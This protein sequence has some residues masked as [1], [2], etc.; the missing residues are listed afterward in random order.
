MSEVRGSSS[1]RDELAS[2]VSDSGIRYAAAD[3]IEVSTASFDAGFA[4]REELEQ[5]E[6]FKDQIKGFAIAWGE[7]LVDLARGCKDIVEQNVLTEDS[8]IVQ[9]LRNPCAKAS[10][11]LRYLNEFCRRIAIRLTLGR[12]YSWSINVNT[13]HD[14]L[15][16]SVK[17]VQIHP[18]SASHVLLPDGRRLAY[19]EQGV[20]A[21]S[22]RFL[23]IAPHSFLSSR[24][25][26]IPGIKIS[27]LV[28]FGIRLVAYDLPG[29]GE[30]DP[31]PSRNLN[32][33]ALD[34]LYLAN[35]I[36]VDDKFW[37]LGHSSGTMHAWASL[38]YIPDRVAGAA[39]VGPMINPYEPGMTKEEKKK[40]WEPW[41]LRRRLMYFLARRFPKFLSSFYRRSF[42]SGKHDRIDK[43]LSLSLGKKDE[44]LIEDPKVEEHLQRDIEESIRQGSIKPFIE[45]AVLQVSRWGFS[46]ADLQAQK[47]CQRRGFLAWLWNSE[48]ECMLTGFLGQIH[49]WQVAR[50][51]PGS[52]VHKLPNEDHFSYLYFCDECHRQI[53]TTL[54]GSPQGPVVEK[55]DIYT[56]SLEGN[57]EEIATNA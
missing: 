43:W 42:L 45:E 37:V 47:Q 4:S 14:S 8:Y 3:P 9:K 13:N 21:K 31:H 46:L 32:S 10:A 11:K 36:G 34:M 15:V 49:I 6:N 19:H 24:L 26:G 44:I 18:P 17:K 35:A 25:A 5:S 23:L 20:P 55:L 48:A 57:S 51:L 2:L 28:E 12:L 53:F 33:S 56:T 30:S 29:F 38:R 50:V 7:I 27:L 54:F 16:R 39:M 22:T 1:W 41:V 40:T 52:Y